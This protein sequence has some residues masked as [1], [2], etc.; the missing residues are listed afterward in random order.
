V[1]ASPAGLALLDEAPRTPFIPDVIWA[2]D[3]ATGGFVQ[4]AKR[5][6][7]L[8]GRPWSRPTPR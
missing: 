5:T 7:A 8:G 4:V 3:P 6:T 2:E 1:T